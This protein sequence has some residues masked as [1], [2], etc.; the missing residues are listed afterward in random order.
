MGRV[1]IRHPRFRLV[2]LGASSK[3]DD[4]AIRYRLCSLDPSRPLRE[5]AEGSIR[6]VRQERS[7][8]R[9]TCSRPRRRRG[10][11]RCTRGTPAWTPDGG[12]R[13]ARV[14]PTQFRSPTSRSSGSSAHASSIRCRRM[15]ARS[16]R[17]RCSSYLPIR[18]RWSR[19]SRS[20][21]PTRTPYALLRRVCLD[22]TGPGERGDR[23]L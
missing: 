5:N 14:L 2:P 9:S 23:A 17:S 10:L 19:L 11:R 7:A 6:Q 4:R 13:P 15:S 16:R 1:L 21:R 18:R 22:A 20:S 3:G 8:H 12:R